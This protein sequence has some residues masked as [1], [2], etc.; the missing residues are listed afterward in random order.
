MPINY[1]DYP[2][3]WSSEI[4]PRIL[5]R[6]GNCCE[7]C[8]IRN[9]ATPYSIPIRCVTRG[10]VIAS[11][12]RIWVSD[13]GDMIRLKGIQ[14]FDVK[15]VRVI[16][17][18][19]HLDHDVENHDVSDDRL[20]AMCQICHLHYDLEEKMHRVEEANRQVQDTLD[21]FSD[22]DLTGPAEEDEQLSEQ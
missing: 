7:V 5:E 2:P 21:G 11:V 16:L 19:G 17:T 9:R 8:G 4:V 22:E 13:T 14:W 3:N 10:Q 20:K 15:R 18:V 1:D 6:A 12:R